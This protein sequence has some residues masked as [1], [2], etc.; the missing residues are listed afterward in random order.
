MFPG[1]VGSNETLALVAEQLGVSRYLAHSDALE[2]S[3]RV[4]APIPWSQEMK[5]KNRTFKIL[6]AARQDGY[7]IAAF[8]V[9]NLEGAKAAINA[10]EELGMSV[11]LQVSDT[12]CSIFRP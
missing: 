1:N 4:V 9:Y 6:E 8:N 12:N 2:N 3:P 5:N 11:L 10:A 7:A